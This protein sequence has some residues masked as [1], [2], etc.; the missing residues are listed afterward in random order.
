MSATKTQEQRTE[1]T[2][3]GIEACPD[4]LE[5]PHE[6]QTAEKDIVDN[7]VS[8]KRNNHGEISHIQPVP[9]ETLHIQRPAIS[10]PPIERISVKTSPGPRH[11][12]TSQEYS[13]IATTYPVTTS[14][15]EYVPVNERVT[16]LNQL[17]TKTPQQ[18]DCMF[19]EK[20]AMTRIV[21]EESDTTMLAAVLC[22]LT[23]GFGN[24]FAHVCTY[25]GN[26]VAIKPNDSPLQ[27]QRPQQTASV[28]S[29]FAPAPRR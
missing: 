25:C 15:F 29:Q 11:I 20:R 2:N 22:C 21:E 16:P 17:T 9:D 13:S 24:T 26:K 18:I 10:V 19:C 28:P 8:C 23:F 14:K 5:P 4:T 3:T 12:M 27:V 7:D 1:A 6:S